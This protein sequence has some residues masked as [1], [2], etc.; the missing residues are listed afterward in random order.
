LTYQPGKEPIS[1]GEQDLFSGGYIMEV[2]YFYYESVDIRIPFF[3]C[4]QRLFNLLA[5]HGG[6]TWDNA[7]Q[8]FIFRRNE[9]SGDF[10]WNFQGIPLVR[11]EG[12]ALVPIRIFNFWERP[13]KKAADTYSPK[14]N[15][16]EPI[17]YS[18]PPVVPAP[19]PAPPQISFT[20]LGPLPPPEKL[21]EHW[22]RK[23]EAEL[24]SRKYSPRTM[25]AYMYYNRLLCRTLQK[26]PEEIQ[27]DD[28]TRFLAEMEKDREYS[29]SAINLAISSI[30]FFFREIMHSE[31]SES[32]RP[33]RDGRL[34]QVLS[35]EEIT[36]ILSSES[37]PKHR[38]LLMLVYSSGL[39]VSEV[40]ALK[41]EHID[42]DRKVI[43]IRQGKGRKDR[44][45]LLSEKAARFI[46]EYCAF[47]GIQTWL[48]PGQP[49][50]HPLTIRS[51]QHIFDKAVR[52]AAIPKKISI[53]GLRHTFATHLLETGTD[54]RYIQT[55]LGHANL[56]T[57]ERYTHVARRSL[58]NIKSPLDTL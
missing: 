12:S 43:Y 40:V 38:L 25:R 32:H 23:L 50:T 9:T 53:H 17:N 20:M 37:N 29:A 19:P 4:N 35:K 33:H 51:A 44:C 45:T 3:G 34:P 58:L 57:T 6:G 13:W 24:R 42:I 10:K 36:R 47:F 46:T 56:R 49:S 18:R 7:R 30:K 21:S 48:F 11:V 26:T 22:Q 2:I 16:A 41:R 8:E 39:R 1:V 14:Q 28:I 15:E 52:R 54:I 27:R 5:S 31:I 55:L